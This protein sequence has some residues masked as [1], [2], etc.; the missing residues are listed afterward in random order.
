MNRKITNIIR[1]LMDECIPAF[2]RDS[3]WFMYPFYFFAYRG[4]NI[5]QVMNFKSMVHSLT[6][7]DYKSFY[8]ELNSISRN[9]QTDLSED[10]IR[11]VL[12]NIDKSAESILDVGCGRGYL[13]QRIKKENLHIS[14]L[15]TDIVNKLRYGAIEF[16]QA[17]IGA[18]PFKDKEFDTVICTH[19]IE[20]I[21]ELRSA[22][23]ELV[24]ITNKQLIIVTPCQRYFYYTLDE[25]I[26][27]F[28]KKEM[29]TS[30][31]PFTKFIFKKINFDWVYIGNKNS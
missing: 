21:L 23:K 11:F 26:N 17:N 31:L 27:F 24:R 6:E 14:L 16:H 15:G 19:T 25:H 8:S 30:L 20:H 4:G 13:L 22:I 7:S 3:Y 9:R 2:I 28:H 18:M 1:V 5:K 12:Q 10:Q 29:L